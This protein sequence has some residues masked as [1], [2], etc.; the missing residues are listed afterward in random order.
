[1][2]ARPTDRDFTR[3]LRKDRRPASL[4]MA[5]ALGSTPEERRVNLSGIYELLV[6]AEQGRLPA[7]V[8]EEAT[9]SAY[10]AAH[11]LHALIGMLPALRA[12]KFARAES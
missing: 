11:H 8:G 9:G 10:I 5:D 3:T 1:V 6:A 7:G 12:A 2:S 4:Q